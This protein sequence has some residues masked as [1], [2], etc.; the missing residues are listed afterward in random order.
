MTSS[1]QAALQ[2]IDPVP[3]AYMLVLVDQ[4]HLGPEPAQRVL[5]AYAQA[6]DRGIVIPTYQGKRGHPIILSSQ[7]RQEVLALGP[8]QGLNI[9]TRGHPEATLEVPLAD[10]WILHDMDYPE[11]YEAILKQWQQRIHAN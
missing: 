6:P 3:D 11:E 2:Q 4:P 5:A 9:V 8:D 7:Y 1:V 10:D